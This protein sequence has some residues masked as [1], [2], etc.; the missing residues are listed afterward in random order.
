[1]PFHPPTGLKSSLR[2][3]QPKFG[4]LVSS[5]SAATIE[6]AA[7]QGLDYVFVDLEHG[8]G[9]DIGDI[10]HLARAAD[11]FG[12]PL[13]V[14]VP[15]NEISVCQRVL[16]YGALGVCVPHISTAEQAALAVSHTKFP[17]DGR[18][19]MAPSV[20]AAGYSGADW[21]RY[22]REANDETL[23]I[24]VVEDRE[25]IA[26]LDEIAAV[27]GVDVIWIGVG[28]LSQD[29]DIGGQMTHPDVVAAVERGLDAALANGV[30]AM[31]GLDGS[32]H[33]SGDKREADFVKAYGAGSRFFF[34]SEARVIGSGCGALV[35]TVRAA[36]SSCEPR[37]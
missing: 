6:I 35:A 13:I 5:G 25:G 22:W 26:N 33:S 27:P 19:A 16:D 11:A 17:P 1:M 7:V 37:A 14:R 30:S 36:M 2:A 32:L 15:R 21:D 20:R 34:W 23:V 18:R 12:I 24:L 3:G 28:D 31:F 4:L 10:A 29:M 8:D 9:T